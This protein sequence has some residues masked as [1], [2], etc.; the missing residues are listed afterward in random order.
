MKSLLEEEHAVL[1]D[2]LGWNLR[3]KHLLE[4][5]INRQYERLKKLEISMEK[6]AP[7]QHSKN[8]ESRL[9]CRTSKLLSVSNTCEKPDNRKRGEGYWAMVAFL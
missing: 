5:E 1:K 3:R 4:L 7:F 6:P 8:G 9:S 2:M